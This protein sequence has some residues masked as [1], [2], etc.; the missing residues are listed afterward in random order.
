M[1]AFFED[2]KTKAESA[3]TSKQPLTVNQKNLM[4]LMIPVVQQYY[5]HKHLSKEEAREAIS[6]NIKDI[7][8]TMERILGAKSPSEQ[9]FTV[10]QKKL[11]ALMIPVV[12]QYYSY[13]HLSK[14]QAKEAII[15]NIKDIQEIMG[16]I[17]GTIINAE[18]Q[19]AWDAIDAA[20]QEQAAPPLS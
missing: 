3:S 8:E 18:N 20:D 13:L 5:S 16:K 17:L 6:P 19:Q 2:C 15:P 11:I 14:E 9:P 7:Q 1:R 10:N 4:A 12:Q